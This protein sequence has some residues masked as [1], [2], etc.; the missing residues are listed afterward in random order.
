MTKALQI[1]LLVA[2]LAVLG[3]IAGLMIRGG[4]SSIVLTD[5]DKQTQKT[6][7]QKAQPS[8]KPY[9]EP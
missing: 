1:K 9:L 2:I 4:R 7:G 6:F 8:A 3:V 5:K